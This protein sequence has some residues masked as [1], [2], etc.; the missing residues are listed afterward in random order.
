MK[1]LAQKETELQNDYSFIEDRHERLNA[2]MAHRAA[3][4]LLPKNEQKP[5]LLVKGCSSQVWLEVNVVDNQLTIRF[6][7]DAVMVKGLVAL[8]VDL[9]QGA[10]IDDVKNFSPAIIDKLGLAHMLSQTRLNGIAQ[11]IATFRRVA[12]S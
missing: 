10:T 3:A 4:Y 8:L 9:Y 5:E 7:A 11:V 1:S 2:I 6:E 12:A